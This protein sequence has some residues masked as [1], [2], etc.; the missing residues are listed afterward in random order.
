VSEVKEGYN[1]WTNWETWL[2]N[3]W[4]DNDGY[5]GGSL[6]VSEE[7]DRIVKGKLDNDDALGDSISE[8]AEWLQEA[9]DNDLHQH[10]GALVGLLSDI[11]NDFIKTVD[12]RDIAEHYCKDALHDAERAQ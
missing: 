7:A 5:A 10:N 8:L 3:L 6:G 9:I 11:V 1:G 12:W 2:T 4:I